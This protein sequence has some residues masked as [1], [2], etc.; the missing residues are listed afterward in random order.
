MNNLKYKIIL[1]IL[2]LSLMASI[3]LHVLPLAKACGQSEG[4]TIVNTSKYEK[5]FGIKNSL[6]GII[7]FSFLI[8]ILISYLIKKTNLKFRI[9]TIGI[10]FSLVV[11]LYFLG[12]QIYILGA[13]CKYCMIIDIGAIMNFFIMVFWRDKD[14]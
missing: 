12:I 6:I 11:S 7:G 14:V 9:F 8:I 2:I 1:L 3:V 4:C 10:L 13:I 5:T